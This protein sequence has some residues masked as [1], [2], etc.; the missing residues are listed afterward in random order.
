MIR[1]ANDN[2]SGTARIRDGIESLVKSCRPSIRGAEARRTIE[3]F[4]SATDASAARIREFWDSPAA[5]MG[6]FHTLS[7]DVQEH[8]QRCSSFHFQELNLLSSPGIRK[9]AYG[10]LSDL[11]G[12]LVAFGWSA[13]AAV[14]L[15][16]VRVLSRL[17]RRL[18]AFRRKA[19]RTQLERDRFTDDYEMPVMYALWTYC[20][21]DIPS[22]IEQYVSGI[23]PDK[24]LS[25]VVLHSQRHNE[26]CLIIG[27]DALMHEGS[28]FF[29]ETNMNPGLKENR[30]SIFPSGDPVCQG[31]V[32]YATERG[33]STIDFFS[34][35]AVQPHPLVPVFSPKL[36]E[37]WATSAAEYGVALRIVDWPQYGAPGRKRGRYYPDT[38]RSDTLFAFAKD[39]PSAISRFMGTKGR[40]DDYIIDYNRCVVPAD[41]IQ[42]PRRLVN[43]GD[44]PPPCSNE[45]FPNLILKNRNIDSARGISLHRT[46]EF[47]EISES[48]LVYEY[49]VPD[50]ERCDGPEGYADYAYIFRIYIMLTPNGPRCIGVRKD[51]SSVAMPEQLPMGKVEDIRPYISNSSLHSYNVEPSPQEIAVGSEFGV[52]VGTCLYRLLTDKYNLIS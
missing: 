14:R 43:S 42:L 28:P 26:S 17:G 46:D 39:V 12:R 31:L 30:I 1:D 22:I 50:L 5:N 40:F 45:R 10:F 3:E 18:I 51:I 23:P 38:T 27:I 4:M 41:Q 34:N 15:A 21:C 19:A 20:E 11:G 52:K 7:D 2:V 48:D 29:V 25:P 24:K 37:Y 16:S 9:L 32:Q 13:P 6:E 36:E 49:V 47:P 8:M 44:I 35:N 33:L